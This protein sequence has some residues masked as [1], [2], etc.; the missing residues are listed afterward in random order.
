MGQWAG[1]Y[2]SPYCFIIMFSYSLN[3]FGTLVNVDESYVS[4]TNFNLQM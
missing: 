3:N 4:T 1:Y 2:T